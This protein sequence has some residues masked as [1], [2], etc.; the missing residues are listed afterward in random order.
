[1]TSGIAHLSGSARQIIHA[2]FHS[3]R[4]DGRLIVHST[5]FFPVTPAMGAK[6]RVVD[7]DEDMCFDGTVTGFSDDFQRV[8]LTM[9]WQDAHS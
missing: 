7:E 8:F 9:D 5:R 4:T 6:V 3:V 2:D 1:M